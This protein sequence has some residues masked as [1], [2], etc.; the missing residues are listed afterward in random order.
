MGSMEQ[1]SGGS[2]FSGRV[3]F[4][5]PQLHVNG[6]E[7]GDEMAS[8]SEGTGSQYPTQPI[9]P[10]GTEIAPPNEGL[11]AASS[12]P[13]SPERRVYTGPS[14]FTQ[15]SPGSEHAR[16]IR[17]RAITQA[18]AWY[19]RATAT[20]RE[21]VMREFG[22]LHSERGIN[23]GTVH[24]FLGALGLETNAGLLVLSGRDYEYF[25]ARMRDEGY[26]LNIAGAMAGYETELDMAV[27]DRHAF[28]PDQLGAT[29]VHELGGHATTPSMNPDDMFDIKRLEARLRLPH[30]PLTGLT[31]VDMR[32]GAVTG[33][34]FD[35][36]RAEWIALEYRRAAGEIPHEDPLSRDGIK[37]AGRDGAYKYAAT[38]FD[39]LFARNESLIVPMLHCGDG[40]DAVEEV[41]AQIER[42]R[43][44]LYEDLNELPLS[45]TPENLTADLAHFGRG[46]QIVLEATDYTDADIRPIANHGPGMQYIADRLRRHAA[47]GRFNWYPGNRE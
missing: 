39:V 33:S 3:P 35:E 36:G 14:E 1:G 42:I 47:A 41:M 8:S 23:M 5:P 21:I 18:T 19:G 12:G 11:S 13:P 45:N 22:S 26:D 17:R 27:I 20:N 4:T 31:D 44:G 30:V 37:Y 43:P 25:M 24:S 6:G 46:L 9:P 7:F 40:P 29:V 16:D 34:F 38:A 10:Y 15:V 32:T 28:P 2:E